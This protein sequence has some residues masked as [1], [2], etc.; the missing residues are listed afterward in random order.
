MFLRFSDHWSWVS[1]QFSGPHANS[2]CA[3]NYSQTASAKVTSTHE[4]KSLSTTSS[5]CGMHNYALTK[6]SQRA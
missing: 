1:N 5:M 6:L 2:S 3:C 4:K